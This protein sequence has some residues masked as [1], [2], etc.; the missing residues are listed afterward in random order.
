MT[1]RVIQWATGV[2][3]ANAVSAIVGHP[4]LELVGAWVHSENKEGRDVGEICGLKPVGV[5]AT[6]DK[7]ALLAMPADCICCALSGDLWMGV[8]TDP[9]I[10]ELTSM[11]RSGKNV[12]NATMPA[13]IN[14]KYVDESIY[15]RLQEACLEGG[16][17]FYTDGIDPGFGNV[18]LALAALQVSSNTRSVRMYEILNYDTWHDPAMDT[19]FGF[20]RKT[21]D[22]TLIATPGVLKSIYAS[23]VCGVAESMGVQVDE[24]VE[25]IDVVYA[26]EPIDLPGTGFHVAPGTIS[27]VRFKVKGMI[28]GEARVIV[29]HVTK[30]REKDFPEVPF[31]GGG[32][33]VEVDGEPRVKLD[34]TL[35]SDT[36]DHGVSALATVATANVNA[37]PLVCEAPPGVLTYM[38]LKPHPSKM[39]SF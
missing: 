31:D 9:L 8:D 32:Y 14:P 12:V 34:L 22:N 17:T 26:D 13:L 24:I 36:K 2:V 28:G 16:T 30:L 39:K 5:R 18:G 35:S 15:K 19:F 10:D 11:L 7:D 33:R 21:L 1:Y 38:D 4:D 3:G 6:R 27:G 37:I 25:E 23:T 20:G 29:D